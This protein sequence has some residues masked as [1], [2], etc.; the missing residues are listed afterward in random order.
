M[1]QRLERTQNPIHISREHDPTLPGLL[2]RLPNPPRKIIVLRASRIG[3]FINSFP[4]LQALKTHLP[5]SQLTVIT[6]PML[7]DIAKRCQFIDHVEAFPGYPGMADQLF[8]ARQALS[9]FS[10]IQSESFDL[11]IQMQGSG[12]YSNPFILMLGAKFSAGF[13][14][15]GDAP[16]RLDAALPL[17]ES[18]YE[19]DRMLALTTF[20]G[21]PPEGRIPQLLTGPADRAK[22]DA[23]LAG[24]PPPYI[25]LHASARDL[26]R[27]WSLDRF[28]ETVRRLQTQYAGTVVILGEERDRDAAGSAMEKNGIEYLNLAGQTSLDGLISVISRLSILITNDTGPAHI[29]YAVGT[30]AVVIFGAGDPSRNGPLLS[31]PF[32]ILAHPV[33]CRPCEYIECPIGTICLENIQVEEVV[34]ASEKLLRTKFQPNQ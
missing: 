30:P 29:A 21:A 27:R 23:I 20:L 10:K 13:I 18:G 32:E 5:S 8:D 25:G 11:A 33:P 24:R 31:G 16:G 34:N 28:T 4:A 2:Q 26:T 3:D 15:S 6:L 17:P 1:P 12:V 19:V 22:S 14:R 7:F 9:L